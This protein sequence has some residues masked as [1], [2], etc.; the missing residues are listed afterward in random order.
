MGLITETNREYYNLEQTFTG[1]GVQTDFILTFDPL[2][3]SESDFK[4]FIGGSEQATSTYVFPKSGTSNTIA[5]D[6]APADAAQITVVLNTSS[7]GKYQYISMKDLVRNFMIQYIGDGKLLNRGLRRDVIFHAKRGIQEFSYDIARVEKI[8]EFEIGTTL[9][10]PF[11]QDYVNYVSMSWVDNVGV[12][13][14]IPH[15]RITSRPSSAPLQDSS[16]NFFFDDDESLLE[17]TPVTNQRFKKLKDEAGDYLLDPNY[18]IDRV[19]K[20]GSRYGGEPE[21]MND[22]GMFVVDNA[23]GNFAFSSNL[24]GAIINLKYVSDGM[25]TD[26]EMR[27]HKLAE[28]ALYKYIAF[29]MASSMAQIPEY[30]INRLRRDR[31]AAMRNAKLRLQNYKL[32][33]LTNVMRGKSKHLKH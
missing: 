16:G 9:T 29:M 3:T 10:M 32:A 13:H 8:L 30:I 17:S 22:N 12:E 28:E 15:G 19:F 21:L 4:V 2:P 14:P 31:R 26:D 20:T 25:G 24:Q 5:F 33:E 23:N 18:N 6:T 27:I 11:P 1:T 7:Y